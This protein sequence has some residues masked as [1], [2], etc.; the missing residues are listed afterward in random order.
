MMSNPF[1]EQFLKAGLTDK[2]KVK[3]VQK[4]QKKKTR[5]QE[6]GHVTPADESKQKAMQAARDKVEKDRALN[7]SREEKLKAKAIDSQIR[8]LI[9]MNAIHSEEQTLAFSFEVDKKIKTLHVDQATQ[10][11]LV[12]GAFCIARLDE[13]FTIIPR[14][15]ADKIIQRDPGYIVL[16]NTASTETPEEEDAYKDYQV[17]DDLMW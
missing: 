6:K 2:K 16:V 15:A 9:Q 12:S 5:K 17:P 13:R 11:K 10:R 14:G 7:R 1:Q 4:A 3:Q 8:Q